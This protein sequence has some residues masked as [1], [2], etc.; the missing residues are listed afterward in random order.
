M[1]ELETI[2]GFES[3]ERVVEIFDGAQRP[4]YYLE[5]PQGK[6]VTFNLPVGKYY[7]A[8]EIEP[9]EKPLRYVCPELPKKE[10]NV[11][12]VP[13]LNIEVAANPNKA[14]YR[15]ADG[16]MLIDHSI[17]DKSIP[18]RRFV[19]GHE[20]GHTYYFTEWKCDVFSAFTMLEQGYNPSQCFYAN[21]HCLSAAQDER[22]NILYTQ[23]K[24]VKCYE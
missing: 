17:W 1:L 18:E 4:F 10:K 21:F 11:P 12:M 13:R 8:C 3:T 15:N 16:Y 9:L 24:K 2:T 20:L 22:K 5:N 7:P 19:M 14:S 23:L 6:R